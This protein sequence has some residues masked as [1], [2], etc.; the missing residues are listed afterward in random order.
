[1]ICF[2]NIKINIGLDIL[3]RRPD[4]YHNI[5]S[6]FYPVNYT[7]ILEVLPSDEF[8]LINEGIQID[9]PVEKNLCYKAWKLLDEKYNIGPVK[10]ILYKN[11]P[12]GTGLGSGSSD[13]TSTL[14]LLN[15]IFSLNLDEETLIKHAASIGVDCAFF[16]KN[17]P[18]FVSGIGTIFTDTQVDLSGY[19]LLLCLPEVSVNTSSAYKNCK[20]DFPEKKLADLVKLPIV[21]W[22]NHIKNDFEASIF[23]ENPI[24]AEI[25]QELYDKGAVYAQ[26]SGSGSAIYGIFR[27]DCKDIRL[28]ICKKTVSIKL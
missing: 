13:A 1:M 21:E 22:K 25:K 2:P 20:P 9:C 28:G 5:E 7:D 11:V 27:S 17:K 19:Y 8:V 15:E 12:F 14:L 24:L 10:I 23:P 4:G 6:V 18:T 3:E 16:V 26:M